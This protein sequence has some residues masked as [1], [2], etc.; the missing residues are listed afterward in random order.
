MVGGQDGG[1]H[2]RAH[3]TVDRSAGQPVGGCRRVID[4]PNATNSSCRMIPDRL[5]I[6][7]KKTQYLDRNHKK[8]KKKKILVSLRISVSGLVLFCF[9]YFCK[10]VRVCVLAVGRHRRPR[11]ADPASL[12]ISPRGVTAVWPPPVT[13]S[14]AHVLHLEK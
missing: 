9:V 5:K 1:S 10:R 2:A 8:K 4:A 13:C 3:C 14:S 6:E 12:L 7:Q 11:P